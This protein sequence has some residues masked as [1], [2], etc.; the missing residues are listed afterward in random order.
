MTARYFVPDLPDGG[1]CQMDG[2]EVHHLLH[3]MRCQ[4]GDT[5]E[6]FNG[7]GRVASARIVEASRKRASLEIVAASEVVS[8]SAA[9][10]HLGV[11]LP[12]GDRQKWLVEKCVE[13]GVASLT[14]LETSRSVA[15]PTP[16]ALERLR[17]SVV[18]ACKQCGR[19]FLM[20]VGE[21]VAFADWIAQSASGGER[22]I[23]HPCETAIP[24]SQAIDQRRERLR[25]QS[26]ESHQTHQTRHEA[27]TPSPPGASPESSG[28]GG[29]HSTA[30]VAIG[31]EG[32]LDEAEMSLAAEWQPIS[33]GNRILRIETAAV[34]VA[35]AN[36]LLE[37]SFE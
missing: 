17:R 9:P 23:A 12:K 15:Q 37:L 1:V 6:L 35:A 16:K 13:L 8:E 10:L 29:R 27:E 2:P 36:L 34:T 19:N 32:G 24:L 11:A 4:V 18:E 14:P 20:E 3:V 25:R 30:A 31:P 5:I 26:R 33:L 7:R 22:W 28:L 21:P